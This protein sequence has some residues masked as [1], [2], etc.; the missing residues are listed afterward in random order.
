MKG[1]DNKPLGRLRRDAPED[2]LLHLARRLVGERH[3]GNRVTGVAAGVEEVLNLAGDYP[4]LAGAGACYHEA[5]P[6]DIPHRLEL[7]LIKV[8]QDPPVQGHA[9]G[10]PRHAFRSHR[11]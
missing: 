8:H 1:R 6:A 4:G 2:A 11:S 5:R 3:C 10:A 7:S 9:T